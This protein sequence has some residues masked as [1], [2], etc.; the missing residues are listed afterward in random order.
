[1]EFAAN[2]V[3]GHYRLVEKIG[4]GGMGVVWRALDTTLDREVAIKILPDLFSEDPDRLARFE[5]EAKLLASLNHPGI[6]TIHGLH[7]AE[8]IRFLAMELAPGIDLA[9]RLAEGPLPIDE[10]LGIALKVAEALEA[11]HESG[12]VHRDLK[13]ANIQVAPDLRVKI[14]DFG[15][16]KALEAEATGGSRASISPTLTTPAATRLGVILGTASYMSPEQ[17]KGKNVDRRT[18]NWSFGCILYE[19]LAGHR[20]FGGEGVSEVL[21]AVI[22]SPVNF[23]DLPPAVPARVR[24]LVRRCL[25]KDPRRRLRDIGEARFVLE[26][27]LSGAGEEAPTTPGAAGVAMAARG[28]KARLV[29]VALGAAAVAALGTAAALMFLSA[30]P[31]GSPVRR[32]EIPAHGPFRS[33][34]QGRLIAISP[35]GRTIAHVE[36]G[37]LFVR[38]LSRT[39]PILIPTSFEPSLIFWSPDS[40]FIGYA[41]GGKL[42]KAPA[43]GGESAMIAD[44]RMQLGGGS[45]ASWCPDGRIV[46]GNGDSAL[47]R[48]SAQ[49]GDLQEFIPLVKDKEGDLHDASCLP[50][51]SVLFV[52]H[53]Q[54]ARPN[55]LFVF[56]QG[57][58]KELLRLAGDQDIWFPVYSPTG[59]ILYHRHP[60]NAGIWALP[61]SLARHE[62]TGEP[63]MVA[64]EG[65][66]PSVSADG[67][68]VHV[69]GTGSRMTQ[70]VWV[71]RSG[72]VLGP[73]G[74][75][76]EQWPFPELSPDGR[77]VV[78]AAKEND[79]DDIWIHDVERGTRT[80][81]SAGNVPYSVEAW[82]PYAESVL[83]TEG[84]APPL[85]MK[86][87]S[88]DGGGESRTLHTGW[89]GAY[90][91]DGRYILF[92]DFSPTTDF[93]VVYIDTKGDGKPVPLVG[94]PGIQL[95][96]RLSPDNRYFAY[97]SDE[98]GTV[99]VYLKRF[100]DA[101]GK[102]QVSVGGG[103]WPR[104]SRRGSRLYYVHEDTIM[105]VDVSPGPEPRL[106]AP[107]A[108]FTRKSLGWPLIFGW[109]PG[110]DVS[111]QEDRF[112][113]VQSLSNKQD[114]TGIMVVEN[115]FK[116]F[117]HAPR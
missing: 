96:P 61:F 1:M 113:V 103:T 55:A 24:Q 45:S 51:G 112:V 48:V 8:G 52:P 54:G 82:T 33:G 2:Q 108:V 11:A 111:P 23:Q 57:Q 62:V 49:G 63:F 16:A 74:P 20:P 5:R 68:L 50:D 26:E 85:T 73:I 65:D 36:T 67:T 72:K 25:E 101:G 12:V 38:P 44:I 10:A 89:S 83:Y 59:H 71:E 116:E 100:P 95:W 3:F 28:S 17:A 109:P 90:S 114:L 102:W 115:W 4:E 64:P 6:A 106:G 21:A 66:V 76:Q 32:F 93:D 87:R 34:L 60:A 79:V 58:R 39:E 40:A 78:I 91:A 35:D 53:A 46:L 81:L 13:P 75:P 110:F 41:A 77:H 19:M 86:L 30:P 7:Q 80:R 105:E 70:M 29:A 98:G 92:A 22:M 84:S 69:K 37:R 15:L 104:W 117:N 42:W 27:I 88:A 94:G 99:E 47:F 9:R 43:G 107:R 14:L 18:D 56:V 97:V 31:E